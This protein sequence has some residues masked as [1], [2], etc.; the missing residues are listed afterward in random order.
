MVGVVES[1]DVDSVIGGEL[2]ISAFCIGFLTT[3]FASG[4]IQKEVREGRCA[5]L[6][7]GVTAG[8]WWRC[9]P[10]RD[11]NLCRRGV[12]LGLEAVALLGLPSVLLI[13]AGTGDGV[14][15]GLAFCV[16][17]GFWAIVVAVP[18][19][20]VVYLAATDARHFPAPTPRSADVVA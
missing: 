14:W 7:P 2:L 1:A 18:V 13:Y 20:L 15:P 11:T 3:V 9:T 6:D 10:V 19:F 5:M 16:F 12:L 4:G 8:G 17:K